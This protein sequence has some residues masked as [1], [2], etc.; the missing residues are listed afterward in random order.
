MFASKSNGLIAASLVFAVF[1][2]GGNNVGVKYLVNGW[3]PIAVGC[4]RFLRSGLL[5]LGLLRWTDWLGKA[6]RLPRELNRALWLRGSLSL[7]VYIVAFNW[8]LVFTSASHLALYLG[9]APVWALLWEGPPRRTWRSVQRYAAATLAASGAVVLFWPTLKQGN[10]KLPGELFGLVASVLWTNYS[11]QCRR[12][13]TALSG[14]EMTGHSM[15]R[16]AILLAPLAL[17]E[18]VHRGRVWRTDYFLIQ[19]CCVVAGGVVAFA[20]WNNALRHWPTSQVFLFNNGVP[21]STLSWAK[22]CLGEP[23]TRTFWFALLLIVTGVVLGQT[24][25]S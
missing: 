7:A 3:P 24:K 19:A 15:W 8:A 25:W 12:F 4:S 5:L 18:T 10:G 13:G 2:W 20:L 21:I 16:A 11:R 14:A 9:A 17:L 23:V 1:L 6:T 22:V